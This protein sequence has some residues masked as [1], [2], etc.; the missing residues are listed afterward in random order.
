[1]AER[2]VIIGGNAAG[3]AAALAARRRHAALD[4]LVLAAE[5]AVSFGACGMP[6]NLADPARA[7]EDL[8]VRPLAA[9]REAGIQVALGHR[10]RHVDLERG[11]LRVERREAGGEQELTWDRLVVASGAQGRA[12]ALPGL[13]ETAIHQFR[14]L[15]DLR[16]L[17]ALCHP[18]ATAV[19]AGAGLVGVELC[20]ALR[21][22]GLDVVLV[23]PLDLP[24]NPFPRPIR[25]AARDELERHGV[26]LALGGQLI[27]GRI[28][29]GLPPHLLLDLRSESGGARRIRAQLLINAAGQRPATGFLQG[30]GLLD[31]GGALPVDETMRTGHA[32][33]WAAGDC[34]TRSPVV[35]PLHGESGFVWN[36]QAREAVAGGRVAGWNAAAG[37][38]DHRR[39]APGPQ[40]MIVRCFGLELARCGRLWLREEPDP[41]APEPSR[42]EIVRGL[43]GLGGLTGPRSNMPAASAALRRAHA[44]ARTLGHAMPG[45]GCLEVWLEAAADGLLRGG[46]ILS[47][48]GGGAQRINVLAALL[49]SGGTAEDLAGLD[50]AYSPPFGPLADPLI[51]AARRLGRALAP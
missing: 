18:P 37:P 44:A 49:Q 39:L 1:M 17:K 6:Y 11:I 21:T 4:I 19:V 22:L 42:E 46:A 48:G 47:E 10:V 23:D 45:S 33:V 36:P 27:A 2:L 28:V 12:L 50:L 16:R 15:D 35:P 26:E 38:G 24:L 41:V 25:L 31:D 13:P 30:S 20:E 34:V 29:D 32:R 14:S 8:Q 43:L 9:F 5:S 3:L 51:Q 40:T 7:A